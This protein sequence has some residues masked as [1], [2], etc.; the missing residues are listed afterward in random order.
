[1][2]EG[3]GKCSSWS[4]Q[5]YANSVTGFQEIDRLMQNGVEDADKALIEYE[6]TQIFHLWVCPGCGTYQ[7]PEYSDQEG[8]ESAPEC[9]HGFGYDE[10]YEMEKVHVERMD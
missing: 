6:K 9:Q 8:E 10:P 3:S 7:L 4:D 2:A 1:M 5:T